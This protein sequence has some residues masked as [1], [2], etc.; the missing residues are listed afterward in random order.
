MGWMSGDNWV[1]S[2]V[3]EIELSA[4]SEYNAWKEW[5]GWINERKV[6]DE[7]NELAVHA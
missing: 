3:H 1:S 4:C 7:L 5:V 2:V 6:V